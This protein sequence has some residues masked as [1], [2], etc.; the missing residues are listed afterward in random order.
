M[1]R[2][3]FISS[4][5]S[6]NSNPVSTNP[7]L[8]V[9]PDYSLRTVIS[10]ALYGGANSYIGGLV[11]NCELINK[12]FP[13]FWV[14]VFV[15]N[16][17][18]HSILE[19]LN[20]F[21]NIKIIETGKSGHINM[22]LR[23]TA[24][25]YDEVGIAFCRDCDSYVNRRDK[26]C[27]RKFLETDKK[28]Q[29]IREHL[30]HTSLIMGGMWAIKKGILQLKISHLILHYFTNLHNPGYG[31]D[32]DFLCKEI[33]PRIKDSCQVFDEFFHFP[34]ETPEKI[35]VGVPYTT[36]NHVGADWYDASSLD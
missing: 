1:A 18:D 30:Q 34:G 7:P 31:D 21:S 17:F 22:S 10:Y 8:N 5:L 35:D 33:Y 9:E 6:N 19:R 23:F 16:D 36:Y 32:Q 3:S 11:K 15:G 13:D 24:I 28:F 25:D 20:T 26:Y 2:V 12:S 27:I 4:K 29:I 14:Y